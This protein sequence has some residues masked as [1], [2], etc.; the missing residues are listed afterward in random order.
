[1]APQ[2]RLN[3]EIVKALNAPDVRSKLDE[4]GMSILGGTPEGFR[5]LIADGIARYGAII[6]AAG[7]KPE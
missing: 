2:A 7:I 1:M 3:G 4:N 5:V 6:A